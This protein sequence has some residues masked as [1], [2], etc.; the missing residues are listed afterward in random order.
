M[1]IQITRS[2]ACSA[3]SP[4]LATFGLC[5]VLLGACS[6]G[7][8]GESDAFKVRATQWSVG[9]NTIVALSGNNIAWIADEASTGPG[10]TDLNG[11][12]VKDDGV[13]VYVDAGSRTQINIG[14][15]AQDLVWIG[16]ELYMVVSE[17]LDDRDWNLDLVKDDIVLV[18]WSR[19]M[20]M[21]VYVDDLAPSS[22]KKVV[23]FGPRLVY[24][25][26]TPAV[27]ANATSLRTIHSAAPLTIV[28]VTSTDT[29]GALHPSITLQE[30]G[31]VFVTLDETL[32]ARV[33]NGDADSTDSFV[34]G[35]LDL[36][37]AAA[38]LHNVG[39]AMASA[40]APVRGKFVATADWQ[41]GF[42]VSEAAQGNVNLDDPALFAPSWQAPQCVGLADTDTN[43]TI[44]HY[45]RFAA[46]VADPITNPARNTGLVGVDKIAIS[47][48]FIATITPE[49]SAT[50]TLGEGTCD[51]NSDGD[52]TDRVVRW[53][54]MVAGTAAILPR[55]AAA[56]IHALKDVPGGTRGLAELQE[57]LVIV[58]DEAADNLDINADGF[59]TF[60]L[61]GWLLPSTT[62]V[63]WQFQHSGFVGASW[64]AETF[65]RQRMS[66]A[67]Q[68]I[69]GG[70][71]LNAG[72]TANPGDNDLLDS[73]PTFPVFN[74]GGTLTFPG[75]TIALD[76]SPPT[77]FNPGMVITRG[78]GYYRVAE[79]FDN[80]DWS[81]D[82]S[83]NDRVMFRTSFSQGTT[84]ISGI[85]NSINRPVIEFDRHS[86]APACAAFLTEEALQGATGTDINGDG[87]RND[88]VLQYF[89]F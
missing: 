69:V 76:I 22:L 54:Q 40:S 89:V 30:E 75:V 3:P 10:G 78:L 31:L 23:A 15:A 9:A 24:A 5:A 19:A 25:S 71:S 17:A 16:S 7:S 18:H 2:C 11:D 79:A 65:D 60:D 74:S 21:P 20:P 67:L 70:T 51:L 49:S 4:L 42:L 46:W 85:S 34:L 68:E 41:V 55:N 14:V 84:N 87:D 37:T 43:D 56:N 39:L 53:T 8:S 27:G 32:E 29:A 61:V 83:K 66:L 26:A 47:N 35:L 50:G 12:M 64:M 44:L 13:A 63:P 33:L 48:G 59:K 88:L 38:P 45:L 57:R 36:R 73:I 80:R 81:N 58:V 72:T 6:S 86:S 62:T 52:K 1:R 77:V 28:T 82:G